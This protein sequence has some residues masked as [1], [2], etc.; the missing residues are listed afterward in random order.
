MSP[1]TVPFE[2]Y[3]V[4]VRSRHEFQVLERLTRAG[5]ESFLPV[6]DRLSKRK[7]RKKIVALPL[8]PGY[9][10]VHIRNQPE[11][12]LMTLKTTGVVRFLGLI[13][14][15]PEPVPEDQVLSLRRLVESKEEIDPYPFLKE[16]HKVR[17]R[18]GPLSG[19]EGLLVSRPG[20]HLIV[21][22]VDILQQGVSVKVDASDV[23]SL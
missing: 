6:V 4:H 23:E 20:K 5:I 2:W 10:F 17:I 3:A 7:D 11:E 21:L 12:K 22:S 13:P 14:G 8:F 19:V 15:E 18:K 1:L 16:G 9:L